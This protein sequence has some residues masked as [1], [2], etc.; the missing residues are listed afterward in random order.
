MNYYQSVKNK[1]II[2]LKQQYINVLHKINQVK[3]KTI[4]G[5]KQISIQINWSVMPVKNKTI[6]GLKFDWG[7]ENDDYE[8][9][10]K[11]RL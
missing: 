2:G 7:T 8:V 3:N 10:L 9:M 11:I 4:I 6:I 1:T 5:L